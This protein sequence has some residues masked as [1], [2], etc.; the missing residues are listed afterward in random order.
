VEDIV[1]VDEPHIESAV[2][3]LAEQQKIVGEGAGA[4]G[5]AALLKEPERFAGQRV[6]TVICGGNIDVRLLSWVLNRGLVRDGRMVKLRIGII[7]RPGVLAQVTRLI[8][9]TGGNIIEVFHQRL[10][11]D[12]PAKQ[13]DIDAI[14]E[15]RN[16]EHVEEIV[17]NL[18]KSG[19]P[20]RVLS[21]RSDDLP[22][23]RRI[24][25]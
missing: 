2:Q 18:I 17:G 14:V 20:T 22:D 10:F 9:E 5:I 24:G 1:L 6:G 21:S 7:D 23:P 4:A 8:G 16:R 3:L 12:V 11:Y 25:P 13:A 19:F 15:T